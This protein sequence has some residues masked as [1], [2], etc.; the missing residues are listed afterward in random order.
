MDASH[1]TVDRSQTPSV[2]NFSPGFNV[3]APFIDRHLREGRGGKIAIRCA[4]GEVT[5]AELAANVNRCANALVRLGLAAGQRMLMVVKDCPEF[6]YLFWGAIKAGIV[7]VPLNVILRAP[8]YRVIIED[9][10][11]SAVIFSAEFADEIEPALSA[12]QGARVSLPVEGGAR[13]LRALLE[14]EPPSFDTVPAEATAPCFWLYTSGSTGRPKGA[15][16]SHRDMVAT[17]ELFGRGVLG[18]Q[19]NEVIFSA[20]KLFF[21]YG[22]GNAMTFPLWTGATTVLLEERPTARNT[23]ETIE[24]YRPTLYFG[25]PTLY[26]SQLQALETL[27]ADLS[28]V[29]VCVSAGEPLPA[30]IFRRWKERTGLTILDGLG[31]TEALNT[32]LSNRLDDVRPGTSGRPVPGYEVRVI[33]PGGGEAATGEQGCLRVKGPSTASHYWNNPERT[34]QTMQGDWVDTGDTYFRDDDG[35]Y[36]Y[37]GRSDDMLKVGGIWCS[38]IEIESRLS[39]HQDVFEAAVIGVPDATGIVK[40]EAWVVLREGVTPGDRVAEALVAHCKAQL[41]HYKF[42]RRFHFVSELP[43]T[44][45]GKVQRY[46]LRQE[47]ARAR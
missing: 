47:A 7:P 40:P 15:V 39:D 42:P 31:S 33:A 19:E 45:T 17:S 22:L 26:A 16:H 41:A 4:A 25:V 29:R 1:L 5:Y 20:A 43:K 35:Y 28:S 9:S 36:H 24:R 12:A 6:F 30:E 38:P 8:D 11:C 27:R 14:A 32:F 2:L 34:A 44:A 13:S 10:S 23:L 3:A 18:V 37:C 21:A 46:L